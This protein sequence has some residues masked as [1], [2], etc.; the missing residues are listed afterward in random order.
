VKL[1]PA[2]SRF[3]CEENKERERRAP[4]GSAEVFDFEC[5][6]KELQI[7]HLRRA[8]R[9]SRYTTKGSTHIE[10]LFTG[11][12]ERENMK[13]DP[14]PSKGMFGRLCVWKAANGAARLSA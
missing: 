8:S 13:E 6:S 2:R 7:V 9:T 11:E 14:N 5:L 1:F 12:R 3:D 4:F 10:E